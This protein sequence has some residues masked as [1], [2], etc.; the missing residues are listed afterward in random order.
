M[1]G[2]ESLL[3]AD[4]VDWTPRGFPGVVGGA[5]P[6]RRLVLDDMRVAPDLLRSLGVP[7]QVGIVA[8]LPDEHEMRG[9]HEVRHEGAARRRAWERVRGNAEPAGVIR[10]SVVAP[11]LFLFGE[12]LFSREIRTAFGLPAHSAR[13]RL[14]SGSS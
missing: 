7:Q 10:I 4:A 13:M 8:L 11:Q 9:R 12:L 6:E 5:R 2:P 3:G 14:P 1:P